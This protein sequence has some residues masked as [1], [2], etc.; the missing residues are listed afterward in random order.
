MLQCNIL[1]IF[2]YNNTLIIFMSLIKE[3]Y[4]QAIKVLEKCETPH[5][6]Y[7]AYPGYQGVWARDSVISCL[8]ASLLKNKFKEAFK[9]SLT[10]LGKH[11]NKKGQIPNA[12]LFNKSNIQV[13][14]KSIDSS[15]WFIIGHYVYKQR[16]NDA[17]LFNQQQ[18][19]VNKALVWLSYQDMGEDFM[20]EQLPTT[21]WQDAFPHKYGHT[22]NTQ[23]L[24]Y[25]VLNLINKKEELKKLGEQVNNN[26]DNKLWNGSFYLPWRWKNHNEYQEKGEWFDSLGNLIAIIFNLADRKQGDKIIS[27]IRKN[28]IDK[29]FPIKAIYPPIT[30]NS[31]DWQDYFLDCEARKPYDYLNAGIWTF[32]GGFY[33]LALIK[34]NRFKEAE[35]QLEK[36]AEANLQKPYFS[37]WLNGKTGKPGIS[38]TKKEGN[39]AWNAGMY[40]LAYHCV[41]RRRA[42]LL[43]F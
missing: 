43:N 5:G 34:Q 19:N 27:Y 11:Q 20:L 35:Y 23:A 10:T 41:E 22:V 30:K 7:A 4:E 38:S 6:L 40:L 3:A 29:P 9:Q 15:L 21:D 42:V 8:G 24:Y 37:E 33:V 39:Q 36:L 14:Y 1:G 32:I 25:Y 16:Y 12:V 28:N 26:K 2:I 18:E 31:R 17:R 13:D